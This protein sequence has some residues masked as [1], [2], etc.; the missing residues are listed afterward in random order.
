MQDTLVIHETE[1]EAK[2][3]FLSF[4]KENKEN[5]SVESECWMAAFWFVENGTIHLKRTTWKFPNG[6]LQEALGILHEDIKKTKYPP[7]PSALQPADLADL[8]KKIEEDQTLRR[9]SEKAVRDARIALVEQR[10][11]DNQCGE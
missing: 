1:E 6:S 2:A 5:S 8:H 7:R 11:K 9:A 4:L 3:Q 10:K